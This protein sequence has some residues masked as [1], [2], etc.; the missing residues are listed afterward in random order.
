MYT[1]LLDLDPMAI[2]MHPHLAP[3]VLK[4]GFG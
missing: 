3:G 2:Y 1:V 4:I